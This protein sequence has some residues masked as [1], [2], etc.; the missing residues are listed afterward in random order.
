MPA[1]ILGESLLSLLLLADS[2]INFIT[3]SLLPSGA[4]PIWNTVDLLLVC[5]TILF[6]IYTY[7]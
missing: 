4:N 1:V 7:L 6:M 2:L 3:E 5:L